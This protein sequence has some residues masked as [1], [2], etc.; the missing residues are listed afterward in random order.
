MPRLFAY[1]SELAACL[2]EG[3]IRLKRKTPS[4]MSNQPGWAVELIG[5]D[6]DLADLLEELAPP[7]DPWVET[8][9]SKARSEV[10]LLRSK[11]WDDLQEASF[12]HE[13][14]SF[15]LELLNGALPLIDSQADP[16]RLGGV[17]RFREDGRRD[18][19]A[20]LV[21]VSAKLS[22]GRIR[23]A[24]VSGSAGTLRELK[25]QKWL[26]HAETD[27]LRSELL[28]HLARTNNWFDVYKVCELLR[29]IGGGHGPFEVA[30]GSERAGFDRIWRTANYYRHAPGLTNPLPN[31]PA[32]L[33]SAPQYLRV[34][35]SRFLQ[36]RLPIVAQGRGS[37]E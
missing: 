10:I 12:V 22:G 37:L 36:R 27:D 1:A 35:A 11:K 29:K 2:R 7:S 9:P 23:V 4:R 15:L 21:G 20:L 33:E 13:R 24:G 5:S 16:L 3:P 6:F 32:V 14:A 28:V 17:I 8:D 26:Q 30:L 19:H 18:H 31:P 25:L 34:I